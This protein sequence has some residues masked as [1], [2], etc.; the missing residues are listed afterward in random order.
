MSRKKTE[1]K[2]AVGNADRDSQRKLGMF[3]SMMSKQ[4]TRIRLPHPKL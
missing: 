1:P 3:K 2:V 4:P